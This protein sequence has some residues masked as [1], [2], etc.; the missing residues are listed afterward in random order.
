MIFSYPCR[1]YVLRLF[2]SAKFLNLK[3]QK[4]RKFR[5]LFFFLLR[6]FG[7]QMGH[8]WKPSKTSNGKRLIDRYFQTI[9][10]IPSH[11]HLLGLLSYNCAVNI[12]IIR[13]YKDY[14]LSEQIAWEQPLGGR[15]ISKNST[16]FYFLC[17]TTNTASP[18]TWRTTLH[19]SKTK[20]DSFIKLMGFF[21]KLCP[22]LGL[23]PW[24]DVI[25]SRK[26]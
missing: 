16:N 10:S 11:H 3:L 12:W 1:H 26:L 25:L 2:H 24:N 9:F 23:H 21:L 20:V 15:P 7:P 19:W 13:I 17:N 8:V 18:V 22:K 6:L 5:T 4:L 14:I